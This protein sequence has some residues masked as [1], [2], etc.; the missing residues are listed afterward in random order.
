MH[1]QIAN[2]MMNGMCTEQS[3]PKM[4]AATHNYLWEDT[5]GQDGQAVRGRTE[6]LSC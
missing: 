3:C 6:Y 5:P 1:P 2:F 4:K